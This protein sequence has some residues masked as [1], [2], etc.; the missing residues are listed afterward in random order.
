M[1]KMVRFS[2]ILT[3]TEIVRCVWFFIL[4]DRKRW[5]FI[6]GTAVCVGIVVG[7][8]IKNVWLVGAIWV[9]LWVAIVF[10]TGYF[11]VI[12]KILAVDHMFQQRE[13]SIDNDAISVK[14]QGSDRLLPLATIRKVVELREFFIIYG[15]EPVFFIPKKPISPSQLELVRAMFGKYA[16]LS[17]DGFTRWI[18]H[19]IFNL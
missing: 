2:A 19:V 10:V 4:S 9:L 1:E 17:S 14:S 15:R 18:G 5:L 11:N 7:S 12:K 3:K 13:Y 16:R 6:F 8:W